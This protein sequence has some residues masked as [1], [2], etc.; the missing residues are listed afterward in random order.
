MP[1]FIIGG[2]PV[3][4]PFE[5]YQV[6]RRYMEK[7][8]ESLDKSANSVLESPTG[9]FFTEKKTRNIFIAIEINWCFS[10]GRHGKNTQ[11][12]VFDIGMGFG[13]KKTSAS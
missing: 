9:L 1:E 8:I 10:N 13:E 12:A 2:I 7:V 4:F 5:P 11:F 3:S 6:Q